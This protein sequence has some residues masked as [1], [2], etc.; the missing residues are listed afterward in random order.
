MRVVEAHAKELAVMSGELDKIS[1]S[2]SSLRFFHFIAE[3]PL[4]AAEDS[5][6]FS[7]L[8]DDLLFQNL[9]LL[10]S[11]IISRNER[12]VKERIPIREKV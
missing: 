6:F 5:F 9:L 10:S 11:E 3:D 12:N 4:V 7:R 1:S 2:W 8:E